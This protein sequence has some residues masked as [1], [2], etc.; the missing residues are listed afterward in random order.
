MSFV[1]QGRDQRGRTECPET[2]AKMIKI[3]VT[4]R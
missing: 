4:N 3:D 1:R 2:M